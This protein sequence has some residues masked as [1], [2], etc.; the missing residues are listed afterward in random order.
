MWADETVGNADLSTGYL[1]ATSAVVTIADGGSH[2]YVFTQ[3]KATTDNWLG[4]LLYVGPSG[5]SV[6]WKNAYV[7]IRGDNWDDKADSQSGCVSNFDWETFSSDMNGATFN[8]AVS[9]SEGTLKMTTSVLTS[10]SKRYNYSCTKSIAGTP[11]SVDICLSVN[12]AYLT[13]TTSKYYAP[14]T[15]TTVDATLLHTAAVQ[16]SSNAA[17]SSLDAA[18]HYYNNWGTSGWAAQ[19]YIG[20]SF[21][22]PSNEYSITEATLEFYSNCGGSKNGRT[23]DIY[24]RDGTSFDWENLAL[25]AASGTKIST[26]TD[27]LAVEKKSINVT[28]ALNAIIGSETSGN[29][30]FQLGGAAAGGTLQGKAST[31]YDVPSLSYTYTNAAV[32]SY[33]VNFLDASTG[34]VI[35]SAATHSDLPVGT[36]M[37]ATSDEKATFYNGGSTIKYVYASSTVGVVDGG[38]TNEINVYFNAIP[39]YAYTVNAVDGE[40][41]IIKANIISGSCYADETTVFYLPACVLVDGTLYF[42]ATDYD[43]TETVSSNNQVF[44]YAYTSSSVANV[45]YF[46]E[47]EHLNVNNRSYSGGGALADKSN[48]DDKRPGGSSYLYTPALSG[49]IYTVY[50]RVYG[51]NAKAPTCPLY[52]CNADGSSPVSL[53]VLTP[54]ATASKFSTISVANVNIPE[55]KALCFY[56]GDDSNNS[57]FTIDYVY[58]VKTAVSGTIPSSGFGS[59]ASAYGLD[60]SSATISSGELAAY[61]VSEITKEKAKLT[62]VT[63]MP[64][65]SGVILEGTG[66]AT[67]SIPVKSTATFVGTNKLQAAV[68]ATEVAAD[69]AYILKSGEFCLVTAASTV[70]AGKAY[71]LASDVPSGAKAM[72]FVFDGD[73]DGIEAI[74]NGQKA[75]DNDEIYNLA[76]QRVNKAQKGVFIVNGKKVVVK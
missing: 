41:G 47:G 66:G 6:T 40:E 56:N 34:V 9:Y 16:G 31:S 74:E 28:S 15:S 20:F 36:V 26:Q 64:A 76:G 1:G 71:L 5:S 8:M 7:I 60:F 11:A 57:N 70:P 73:E 21:T 68:T 14:I 62:S 12:A 35:K 23:I 54:A 61:V 42:T 38:A 52:Y 10:E 4:W 50:I 2:H 49:G 18:T 22:L 75:M 69:A 43:K 30:L 67:Y 59:L 45:A 19:A 46:Y 24:Y 55:G 39:K 33:T 63:E 27:N 29:I 13:I 3:A 25:S 72:R 44:S 65:N 17:G 37:E 51:N 32:A 48:G 58:L 53:E